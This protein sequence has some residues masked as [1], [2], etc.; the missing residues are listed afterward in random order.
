MK[1]ER[2]NKIRRNQ[3]QKMKKQCEKAINID[4]FKRKILKEKRLTNF[5]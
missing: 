1:D 4:G 3:Q 5:E 2:W